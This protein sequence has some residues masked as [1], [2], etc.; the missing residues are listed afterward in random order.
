MSTSTPAPL[1]PSVEALLRFFK[2]LA[3]AN[4]LRIVGLLA[5]RPHS[6]EELALVLE[7]RQSTVSHH[8]SRLAEAGLVAGRPDGHHH[9]YSLDVAAL[10]QSARQLLASENLRRAAG[11]GADADAA[12]DLYDRKVL[13]TF[14]GPDGRLKAI[15]MQRKKFEAILRHVLQH[16]TPGREYSGREVDET[17]R[18]FADD[19]ASLRRGLIDHRMMARDPAGTRYWRIDEATSS[20][21]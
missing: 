21:S 7:L 15:P 3:D 5:H 10:E 18:R 17:L 14:T 9:V 19:I 20:P 8:V 2:A 16:F 4:R 13:E 6:V 12:D 11:A 1:D